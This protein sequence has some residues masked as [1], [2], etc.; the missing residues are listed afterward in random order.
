[1]RIL[2]VSSH[3]V[4]PSRAANSVHVVQ[5]CAAYGE[6]G[7]QVTLLVPDHP[8]E[9]SLRGRDIFEFY[10]VRRAFRILRV[11]KPG[12][13]PGLTYFGVIVPVLGLL[14]RPQLVHSRS[15]APAWGASRLLRRRALLEI[16]DVVGENP[17][18]RRLFASTLTA[19][20]FL[21]LVAITRALR[22]RVRALVPERV[23]VLVAPDGVDQSRVSGGVPRS[24]ARTRIGLEKETRRIA[25]YTGHLYRGRGIGTILESARLRPDHLFLVVGGTDA[26]VTRRKSEAAELQNIVFLGFRPPAE[27]PLYLAAADVLLMPYRDK[28]EVAGGGDTSAVASPLK[29]F[30][31]M[32]AGRPIL[33]STLPVLREVLEH[34]RH[35][36][37]LPHSEPSLWAEALGRL[38]GDDHLSRTLAEGALEHV[39][40]FTWQARA[41][42]LA[43]FASTEPRERLAASG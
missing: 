32:A 41:A 14:L 15:L 2:Y 10:G 1:M 40:R 27:I 6:L 7:H 36:L 21:G 43:A 5:M 13:R 9:E 25:V 42:R 18:I 26:D 24:E 17:R 28:V 37:L 16:H 34:E 12:P 11:P 22:E 19:P 39:K 38:A 30:E 3:A 33:A 23:P 35:A 8:T 4:L 29:M 31:Y 20:S